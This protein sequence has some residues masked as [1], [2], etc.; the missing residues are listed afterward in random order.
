MGGVILS[1]IPKVLLILIKHVNFA[2][3]QRYLRYMGGIVKRKKKEK[4]RDN[5]PKQT[6]NLWYFDILSRN[7]PKLKGRCSRIK[8]CHMSAFFYN[9]LRNLVIFF[10][11]CRWNQPA[12]EH[13]VCIVKEGSV[14][15]YS[16]LSCGHTDYI[17]LVCGPVPWTSS[18]IAHSWEQSYVHVYLIIKTKGRW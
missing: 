18:Y 10:L 17:Y 13:R 6:R 4:E 2:P 1:L 8:I 12:T 9:L 11:W 5:S 7:L 14:F 3:I 15:M 16:T